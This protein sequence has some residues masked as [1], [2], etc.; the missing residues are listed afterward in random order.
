MLW[1]ADAQLHAVA[2]SPAFL[3]RLADIPCCTSPR[4]VSFDGCTPDRLIAWLADGFAGFAD[5]LTQG[6]A[7]LPSR[8]CVPMSSALSSKTGILRQDAN[9]NS[10]AAAAAAA[11]SYSLPAV[12]PT[13]FSHGYIQSWLHPV[14]NDS[15][16]T[17]CSGSYRC[18]GC[19]RHQCSQLAI[20]A[21]QGVAAVAAARCSKDGGRRQVIDGAPRC[22]LMVP[23]M[24]RGVYA[25]ERHDVNADFSMKQSKLYMQTTAARAYAS[26]CSPPPSVGS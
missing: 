24:S 8:V 19:R 7:C 20:P 5:S 23:E 14:F 3:G 9:R 17:F 12:F 4:L 21:A 18:R 25:L 1:S 26:A 22:L 15:L 10:S 11:M 6:L 13:F 2:L 16:A